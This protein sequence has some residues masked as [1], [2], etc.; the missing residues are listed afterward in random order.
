MIK[1]E[2][3][4]VLSDTGIKFV[5]LSDPVRTKVVVADYREGRYSQAEFKVQNAIDMEGDK[6]ALNTLDVE[7][8]ESI[9]L[10]YY[11]DLLNKGRGRFSRSKKQ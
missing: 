2:I 11:K 7:E 5:A 1:N 3:L 8:V 9:E 4:I 10:E 6:C